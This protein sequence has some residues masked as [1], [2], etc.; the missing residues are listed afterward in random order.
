MTRGRG[1]SGAEVSEYHC[2]NTDRGGPK[3]YVCKFGAHG[4]VYIDVPYCET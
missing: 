1:G 2:H 4:I 3:Y